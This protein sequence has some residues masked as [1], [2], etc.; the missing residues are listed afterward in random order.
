[1]EETTD[2]VFKVDRGL[3]RSIKYLNA[4]NLII[5]KPITFLLYF[6]LLFELSKELIIFYCR[7]IVNKF[8]VRNA[9]REIATISCLINK[10]MMVVGRGNDQEA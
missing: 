3:E 4:S 8:S 5:G 2:H 7:L 1:M 6:N 10:R 9:D